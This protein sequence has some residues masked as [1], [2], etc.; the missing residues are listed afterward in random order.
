MLNA[1]SLRL[2]HTLIV[3]PFCPVCRSILIPRPNIYRQNKSAYSMNPTSRSYGTWTAIIFP[4]AVNHSMKNIFLVW[5][6]AIN[7]SIR[8]SAYVCHTNACVIFY[9]DYVVLRFIFLSNRLVENYLLD[10]SP[11][12]IGFCTMWIDLILALPLLIDTITC[13]VAI[14]WVVLKSTLIFCTS[15][16]R[17]CLCNYWL[18]VCHFNT[19]DHTL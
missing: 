7:A 8:C 3:N 1:E 17:V 18:S 5:P 10:L 15:S 16:A 13:T 19:W 6:S 4:M 2:R 12:L 11:S 14:R 9:C